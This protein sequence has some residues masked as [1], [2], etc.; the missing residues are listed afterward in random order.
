MAPPFPLLYALFPPAMIYLFPR[1]L[2]V[3]YWTL[4]PVVLG[5]ALLLAKG[6]TALLAAFPALGAF[7]VGGELLHRSSLRF[8]Q[9]FLGYRWR[10]V[11]LLALPWGLG[12][13][14]LWLGLLRLDFPLAL[15]GGAL[16][17]L[18]FLPLQGHLWEGL[19]ALRREEAP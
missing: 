16:A 8:P 7:F 18:G 12:V 6:K 2:W 17:L 11:A 10:W 13:F 14:L 5:L 19:E 9:L 3:R 15:G 4:L 1:S